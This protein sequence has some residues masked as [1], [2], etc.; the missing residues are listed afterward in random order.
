LYVLFIYDK[1]LKVI[2][3]KDPTVELDVFDLQPLVKS[4]LIC[5]ATPDA[6]NSSMTINLFWVRQPNDTD[7]YRER[8]TVFSH[9]V[10]IVIWAG[11]E[12][13]VVESS[14]NQM[15]DRWW[16]PPR[17][18]GTVCTECVHFWRD[19]SSPIGVRVLLRCYWRTRDKVFGDIFYTFLVNFSESWQIYE[20]SL[21]VNNAENHSAMAIQTKNHLSPEQIIQ[22]ANPT[23]HSLSVKVTSF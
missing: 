19:H 16:I 9:F 22:S 12:G 4:K 7:K 17:L 14:K 18:T 23:T 13:A 11:M 1:T 2:N 10:I 8:S 21:S 5:A 6:T 20:S 3:L 15:S